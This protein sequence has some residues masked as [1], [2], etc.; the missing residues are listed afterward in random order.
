MR[1]DYILVEPALPENIGAAARA[2]KTMG[3]GRLVLV[4]PLCPLEGKAE[5]VA[6]GSDDILHGAPLFDTLQEALKGASFSVA[7][8]AKRRSVRCNPLSA[9]QLGPFLRER[10]S[11]NQVAAIVFGREESGLTNEEITMCD[12]TSYIPMAQLYPSLNLGQAVMLYAWE[13]QRCT[14]EAAAED[15]KLADETIS[16]HLLKERTAV[17]LKNL[18]IPP[19]DARHGRIMERVSLLAPGDI[20]LML[21]VISKLNQ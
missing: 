2:I 1:T 8:T 6:H 15:S 20:N 19:A 16:L 3:N 5:W 12:I 7:T 13:M 11:N 18:G 14:T 17:L 9:S 4:N 10:C 21:T